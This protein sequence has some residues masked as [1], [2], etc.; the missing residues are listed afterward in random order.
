MP[1]GGGGSA[2][3]VSQ[4]IQQPQPNPNPAWQDLPVTL[5]TPPVQAPPPMA[6]QP[7]RRQIM[8]DFRAGPNP[9]PVDMLTLLRNSPGGMNPAPGS[10]RGAKRG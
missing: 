3:P 5:P 7:T 8:E 1:G 4:P 10:M 2:P 9:N 6:A